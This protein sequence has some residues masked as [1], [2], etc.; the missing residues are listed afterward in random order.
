MSK[1]TWRVLFIRIYCRVIKRPNQDFKWQNYFD[2][3]DV[4]GYPIKNMSDS[5]NVDWISDKKINV[6]GF[7]TG[8]NPA[9]HGEYWTDKDAVKPIADEIKS[10][11]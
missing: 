10:L 9:S 4:P 1:F 2:A 6:G 5:F 8:W 3:H 7:L 11:L